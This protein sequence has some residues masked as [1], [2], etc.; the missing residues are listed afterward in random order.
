VRIAVLGAGR[1]GRALG[2]RWAAGGH[3]IVYGV[4]DPGDPRHVELRSAA[5]PVDA[6]RS[7][8]VVVLALPWTA[9]ADVV[10]GLELAEAVVIDATNPLGASGDVSGAERIAEWAPQARVVK[11]FNTTGWENMADPAYPA[12]PSAM[13]VAGDDPSAKDVALALAVE[14]GF[15]ALDAG[16]LAAAREL[17]AVA[18]LW[19]RLAGSGHGRQIAF[20]LLRR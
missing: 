7:A 18:A 17:E 20:S 16:P 3:E 12:G 2:E 19:I 1:V 14:L 15:D 11:A 13:L 5:E 10:R 8:D 9:V 4:R 6:I